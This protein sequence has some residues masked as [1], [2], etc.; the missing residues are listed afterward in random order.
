M[1][2]RGWKWSQATVWSV[3]KGERPLRLSEATDLAEVLGILM[4]VL[5]AVP[6]EARV[7]ESMHQCRQA[8]ATL[9]AATTG[10]LEAAAHLQVALDQ[11]QR[12]GVQLGDSTREGGGWLESGP[13]E[14]AREARAAWERA[15]RGSAKRKRARKGKADG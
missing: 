3:E 15:S 8:H 10:Y 1:R 9:E 2:E 12:A 6:E 13:E 4:P 5:L 7:H 11:A 14:V